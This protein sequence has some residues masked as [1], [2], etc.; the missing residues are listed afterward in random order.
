M[1]KNKNS[2]NFLVKDIRDNFP[3]FKD[4]VNG[5]ILTYLDSAA[6]AQ[7]PKRVIDFISK[8]YLYHYSNVHRGAYTLSE[9]LTSDFE[10]SR[11][12]IKKF[13]NA[14]SEKEIIFTKGATESINLVA[15]S[16]TSLLDS[17]DEIIITELEHHSHCSLATYKK[18]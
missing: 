10:D 18:K 13:I 7:K 8:Y 5:K 2:S 3:I 15:S 9:N 12:T 11:S 14:S 16:F 6:S 4:K 17:G 1:D